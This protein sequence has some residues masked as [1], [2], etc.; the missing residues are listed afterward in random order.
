MVEIAV[1]EASLVPS[2]VSLSQDDTIDLIKE[3]AAGMERDMV[4]H[5]PT[6]KQLVVYVALKHGDKIY[7]Y[8]RT[9]HGYKEER[10]KNKFSIGVGGHVMYHDMEGFPLSALNRE[11]QEEAGIAPGN[12]RFLG[13]IND[14]SNEVGRCHLGLAYVV[15]S[16]SKILKGDGSISNGKW[17]TMEEL[18]NKKEEM[19]SWSRRLLSMI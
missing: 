13:F 7:G 11:L 6:Y 16:P 14:D 15:E 10:L 19:E 17:Y 9:F 5:D 8:Y 18:R 12:A 1:I 3:H 2:L 4:E